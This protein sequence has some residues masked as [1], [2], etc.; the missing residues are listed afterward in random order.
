ME[1]LAVGG[2]RQHNP[3]VPEHPHCPRPHSESC[4][5]SQVTFDLEVILCSGKGKNNCLL[6]FC[7]SLSSVEY[8]REL[9]RLG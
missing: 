3:S 2:H 6:P 4:A 8:L 9:P 5:F 7:S 1:A